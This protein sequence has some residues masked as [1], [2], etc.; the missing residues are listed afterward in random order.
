MPSEDVRSV[1]EPE[2]A[3]IARAPHPSAGQLDDVTPPID[4]IAEL[5]PR[6]IDG[7]NEVLTI[8][9]STAELSSRNAEVETL[10]VELER[11]KQQL[12]STPTRL[13]SARRRGNV[14]PADP[15]IE[16]TALMKQLGSAGSTENVDPITGFFT[17]NL[18]A[19]FMEALNHHNHLLHLQDEHA[20]CFDP[21]VVTRAEATD[22]H[23]LRALDPIAAEAAR[24]WLLPRNT[25]HCHWW[26]DVYDRFR[27]VLYR[28]DSAAI[29]HHKDP[30]PSALWPGD[31]PE[32]RSL[33]VAQQKDQMSCGDHVIQF[34]IVIACPGWYP[35]SDALSRVL[36]W[37][38]SEMLSQIEARRWETQRPEARLADGAA[39]SGVKRKLDYCESSI[40]QQDIAVD[41]DSESLPPSSPSSNGSFDSLAS[42]ALTRTTSTPDC[43]SNK[44]ARPSTTQ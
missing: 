7:A 1:T 19:F 3:V 14:R 43:D 23:G 25:P 36:P 9:Q 13:A 10:R 37:D 16:R 5:Q 42:S 8:A 26:L 28:A 31:P 29:P 41:L 22:R 12:E 20:Y 4:S 18:I 35:D 39:I 32:I 11:I 30:L 44:R 33:K 2:A 34:A 24:Y 27:H 17:D 40:P 15:H 21:Q 6:S 38:R